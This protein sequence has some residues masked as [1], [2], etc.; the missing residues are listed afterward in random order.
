[1]AR[2]AVRAATVRELRRYPAPCPVISRRRR[3]A[4]GFPS[5]RLVIRRAGRR[6]RRGSDRRPNTA[7]CLLALF[8]LP[9]VT[10]QGRDP[11]VILVVAAVG[12]GK[13]D[14]TL[15]LDAAHFEVVRQDAAAGLELVELRDQLD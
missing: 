11:Q 8:A 7:R 15:G 9:A 14:L 10:F 6:S 2:E 13:G 5:S 3:G 1:M 4:W 12:R